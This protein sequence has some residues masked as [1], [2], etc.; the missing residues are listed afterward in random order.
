MSERVQVEE[1]SLVMDRILDNID[2]DVP[3]RL[4]NLVAMRTGLHPTTVLRYHHGN[5]VSADVSVL[6]CVL[7]IEE[8]IQNGETPLMRQEEQI[9][10][11]GDATYSDRMTW[12]TRKL[13]REL[14]RIMLLLECS[15]PTPVYRYVSEILDIS[16]ITV[17]CH[18]SGALLEH[19]EEVAGVLRD[20]WCRLESGEAV[21]FHTGESV[22]DRVVPR[23]NILQLVREIRAMEIVPDEA[24]FETTLESMT[25]IVQGELGKMLEADAPRF[26][27]LEMHLRLAGLIDRVTYEPCRRYEVGDTIHHHR[28]GIGKVVEKQHKSRILVQFKGGATRMLCEEVEL[29]P[30]QFRP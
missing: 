9:L 21:V 3:N 1:I 30:Y 17:M 5:I 23:Q 28:F 29:R 13:Q 16:P 2:L 18:S 10:S 19:S 11:L 24:D 7:E 15:D 8:Q 6:Q 22:E 27:P 14:R 4:Y 26:A 12:S 25:G 20:L